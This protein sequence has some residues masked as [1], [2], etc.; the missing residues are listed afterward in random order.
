MYLMIMK[1]KTEMQNELVQ[2]LYKEQSF[3]NL[4]NENPQIVQKRKLC[5]ETL[6]LL[7]KAQTILN[8]I[9]DFATPNSILQ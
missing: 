6:D 2:K 9:R 4:F 8:E 7:Y 1:S 3:E 5:K